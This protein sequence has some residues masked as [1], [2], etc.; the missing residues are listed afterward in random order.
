MLRHSSPVGNLSLKDFFVQL[1]I[2]ME[3][4]ENEL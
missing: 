2:Q 4:F 3:P 1:L